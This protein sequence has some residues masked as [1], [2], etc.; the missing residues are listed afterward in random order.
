MRKKSLLTIIISLL[1]TASFVSLLIAQEEV[2]EKETEK[3]DVYQFTMDIELPH[4]SVKS[5]GRTS[6]CWCFSTISMMESE[7]MR[8]GKDSIDLSEMFIVRHA[9]SDKADNYFRFHG[10]INFAQGGACHDVTDQMEKFGMVPEVVYSGM[11]IGEDRHNHSEIS[12][13]LKAVLD[14]VLK[15]RRPTPRWKEVFDAAADIYL[16]DPPEKFEYEGKKY[17]PK[18]FLDKY[19][20]LNPD[21]YIEITSFSHFPFYKQVLLRLPDNWAYNDEYYNV[22]AEDLAYIIEYSLKEGYSVVFGGDISSNYF[23][24]RECGYAIVP[25]DDKWEDKSI[26][27]I[28]KEIDEPVEEKEITDEMR[29]EKYDQFILTD[30]HGMHIVGLAHDQKG[31]TYF[32]TKNSW[33]KKGKYDG[34]VYMSKSYVALSTIAIMVNKNALPTDIKKKLG[35]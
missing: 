8:M 26:S 27:E 12:T 22:K 35:L 4:I 17:T 31:N 20:D 18:K 7:V 5:Q 30:D 23:S 21:D 2:K 11:N 28:E 29:E 15:G 13:V 1:L 14:G 24:A 16:G 33:G 25:K 9:Y 32:Y 10:K 6:T 34:Y 3:K 19:L